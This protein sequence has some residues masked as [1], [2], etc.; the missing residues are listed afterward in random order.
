MQD[1]KK[2]LPLK[3]LQGPVETIFHGNDH[4]TCETPADFSPSSSVNQMF[5]LFS[6][7][8]DCELE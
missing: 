5:G 8:F 2:K 6:R 1:S 3:Q 4:T 7:I